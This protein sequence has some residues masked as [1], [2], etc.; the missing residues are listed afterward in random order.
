M[1]QGKVRTIKIPDLYWQGERNWKHQKILAKQ[2]LLN[3]EKLKHILFPSLQFCISGNISMVSAIIWESGGV[4]SQG[5]GLY[6]REE[7]GI[8][9]KFRFMIRRDSIGPTI[10]NTGYFWESWEECISLLTPLP[11]RVRTA[12]NEFCIK[13]EKRPRTHQLSIIKEFFK[14]WTSFWGKPI[15]TAWQY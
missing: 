9:G 2:K 1:H 15:L 6:Q 3:R 14:H 13:S 7:A 4:G 11:V 5:N 12:T 10:H 8:N